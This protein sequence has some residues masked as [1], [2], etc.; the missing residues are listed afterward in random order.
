MIERLAAKEAAQRHARP[1]Q[2]CRTYG[3]D[4]GD[5]IFDID[6]IALAD[7]DATY[8]AGTSTCSSSSFSPFAFGSSGCPSAG[9]QTGCLTILPTMRGSM[10]QMPR[11]N[12]AKARKELAMSSAAMAETRA[13]R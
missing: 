8:L 9:I 3:R 10:E 4:F 5:R 6:A 13:E 12:H 2:F 11:A 7:F 1:S